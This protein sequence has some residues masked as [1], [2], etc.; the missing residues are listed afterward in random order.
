MTANQIFSAPRFLKLL[1]EETSS[2]YRMTFVVASVAFVFLLLIFLIN[3]SDSDN[4]DFHQ[5][6]Y[7]IGLLAGGFYFTSTCLIIVPPENVKIEPEVQ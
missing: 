1:R 3:A 5:I 7:S 4:G 6:W 2:G